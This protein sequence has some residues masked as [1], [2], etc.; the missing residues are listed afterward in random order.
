MRGVSWRTL[1][2]TTPSGHGSAWDAVWQALAMPSRTLPPFAAWRH[3]DARDGFEVVFL[4]TGP[5]GHHFEGHTAA[6]ENGQPWAVRYSI[7]TN[8]TW[9]TRSARV[10]GRSGVGHFELRLESDGA[11][12]WLING[13][14]GPQ[15]DGCL[16]VD[17]ESSSFTNAL[18]VR[19]LC[20]QAGQQDEAP[21]AHVRAST[22]P[23]S[24]SSS[25]TSAPTT[26]TRRSATCTRH[27]ALTTRVSSS[28]TPTAYCSTTRG[29]PSAS[30]EI[31]S[32]ARPHR[33]DPD[34]LNATDRHLQADP[35]RAG[36]ARA[37]AQRT[38]PC[39]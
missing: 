31:E 25:T 1:S 22:S 33:H 32:G 2:E 3:R 6:V 34:A 36:V 4:R 19:R 13:S 23:S 38:P 27:R 21:A 37:G 30:P 10:T 9:A 15:L 28:T 12:A 11:G 39:H 20:L 5:E 16:D 29:S 26:R 24:G 17:L 7:V 18:P 8:A 14:P 35:R